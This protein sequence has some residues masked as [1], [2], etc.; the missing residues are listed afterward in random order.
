[1][2][3][4]R[5]VLRLL[6]SNNFKCEDYVKKIYKESGVNLTYKTAFGFEIV[7]HPEKILDIIKS[8]QSCDAEP[9]M[10]AL[11]EVRDLD[12]S[13]DVGANI[14]ITTC[15]LA[16]RSRT[17]YGFEPVHDNINYLRRNIQLN[18][19][20]NINVVPC[21]VGKSSG[22]VEL[23]TRDSFGHH[24]IRRKHVGKTVES[25]RCPIVR[26][27]EFLASNDIASVSLLKI[28]VE[29]AE[30]DVLIGIE[31]YLR[32]KS[33]SIIVFE[34]APILFEYKKQ[35]FEVYD[36]L[37]SFDYSIYNLDHEKV[38]RSVFSTA[39]QGDFYA[40]PN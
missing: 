11:R 13:I 37:S 10:N 4:L 6:K 9:W 3:I 40:K 19:I 22:E 32:R 33:I 21:V 23:F 39:S 12:V 31:N 28:D 18:N 24:G 1:M 7:V 36:Y 38:S 26:L 29:G 34:H 27:D 20:K 35:I 16:Q 15:W 2:N 5:R 8:N 14:G 25:A 17:V 30:I